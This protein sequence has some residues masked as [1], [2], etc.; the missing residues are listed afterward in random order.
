MLARPEPPVS[1]AERVT[2]TAWWVQEPKLYALLSALNSNE[3][4]VRKEA[5]EALGKIGSPEAKYP[6]LNILNNESDLELREAAAGALR[7]IENK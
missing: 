1:V 4:G 3:R 7:K 6:I 2:V 5:I